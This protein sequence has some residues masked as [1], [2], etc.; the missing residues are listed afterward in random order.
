M[1]DLQKENKLPVH[2]WYIF[3]L[4]R[5]LQSNVFGPV[6]IRLYPLVV[7]LPQKSQ[8]IVKNHPMVLQIY[9]EIK[10]LYLNNL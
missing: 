8:W 9:E 10:I 5:H 2:E 1:Q 7:I 6:C 4:L 3:L